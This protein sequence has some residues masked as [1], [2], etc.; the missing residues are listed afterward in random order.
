M[1]KTELSKLT[2]SLHHVFIVFSGH[3]SRLCELF[4]V[5]VGKWRGQAP[6]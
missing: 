6:V 2:N 4:T 3:H 1:M 5:K